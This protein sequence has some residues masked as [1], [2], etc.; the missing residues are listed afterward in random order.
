MTGSSEATAIEAIGKA[1]AERMRQKAAAYKMYGDAAMTALVLEAL[2]KVWLVCEEHIVILICYF[3]SD[4]T[5]N[6]LFVGLQ[7]AAEVAAPLAKTDQ[8]VIVGD[9]SSN[10]TGEVSKLVSQLPPAVQALTGVDL[11]GVSVLV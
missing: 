9:Q 7:V 3:F 6:F 4:V 2:P 10:V 5:R 11:S 8:I 1:E